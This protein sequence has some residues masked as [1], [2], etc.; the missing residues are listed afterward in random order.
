MKVFK[1]QTAIE[2][3]YEGEKFSLPGE[4][5]VAVMLTLYEMQQNNG[6]EST[7]SVD[8]V[9]GMYETLLGVDTARRLIDDLQAGQDTLED[10][11]SWYAEE[12][13]KRKGATDP[14]VK[15]GK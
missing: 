5:P 10:I 11:I 14:K 4:M 13:A 8:D 2:F 7:M 3:E 6:N 1:K 15:P 9:R 12:L